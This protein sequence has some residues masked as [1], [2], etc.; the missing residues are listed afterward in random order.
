MNHDLEQEVKFT[1]ISQIIDTSIECPKNKP[2]RE[3]LEIYDYNTDTML[4][5]N[6]CDYMDIYLAGLNPTLMENMLKLNYLF[7]YAKFKYRLPATLI[8]SEITNEMRDK[9]FDDYMNDRPTIVYLIDLDTLRRNKYLHKSTA[10]LHGARFMIRESSKKI[11]SLIQL[12]SID[13]I[14]NNKCLSKRY[15][16]IPGYG[17]KSILPSTPIN[18]VSL[19]NINTITY[20]CIVEC[21]DAN[22]KIRNF[23][24]LDI[25]K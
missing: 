25:K 10:R 4:Y 5:I 20:N 21:L 17:V 18:M 8:E 22:L 11:K 9:A 12:F 13:W 3:I 2:S 1:D 24:K 6:M 15:V 23:L 7:K 14:E 16:I 19:Y